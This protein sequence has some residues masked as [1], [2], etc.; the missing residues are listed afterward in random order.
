MTTFPLRRKCVH[1]I[2]CVPRGPNRVCETPLRF[3]C[4]CRPGLQAKGNRLNG[5]GGTLRPWVWH[6]RK[7]FIT[8]AERRATE[9]HG[10]GNECASREVL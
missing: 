1:G 10:E 7:H 4:A 6:V 3:S 2:G 9:G 8:E 5:A